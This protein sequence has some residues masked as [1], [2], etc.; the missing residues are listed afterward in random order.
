M[1]K[2]LKSHN[3]PT[4]K[5]PATFYLLLFALCNFASLKMNGDE[6]M[7]WRRGGVGRMEMKEIPGSHKPLSA[8]GEF[9]TRQGIYLGGRITQRTY[10]L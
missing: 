6:R 5:A 10:D 4:L 2:Q 3:R 1:S 9:H 7:R 8:V